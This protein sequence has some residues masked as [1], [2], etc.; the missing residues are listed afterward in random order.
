MSLVF[1]AITPHPPMLIPSIGQ[2]AL[3][4]L[5]KTKQALEKLEQKLYVAH[6]DILIILSPHGSYFKDAFTLNSNPQYQTGPCK[7]RT[8]PPGPPTTTFGL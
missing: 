3:K 4:K 2:G 1:S 7:N 5:E 8:C 6:P